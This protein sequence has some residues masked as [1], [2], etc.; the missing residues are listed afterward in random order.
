M[1]FPYI[2]SVLA[3]ALV[4]SCAVPTEDGEEHGS[5]HVHASYLPLPEQKIAPQKLAYASRGTAGTLGELDATNEAELRGVPRTSARVSGDRRITQ[6]LL[7]IAA[8]GN[9]P[10]YG[11]A[12]AAL[13]RIG[14]PYDTLFAATES[15]T[16]S[17]LTD[18]VSRCHYS[19]VILATDAVAFTD[20]ADLQW[21]SALDAGEWVLLRD[22][23]AACSARE[24][25]W[26]T[27][28]SPAYG[29]TWPSTP[30]TEIDAQLTAAG[31][32]MIKRV[33]PT[34]T[35]TYRSTYL[36]P[37]TVY[38]PTTTTAL[39]QAAD[40]SVL[41]ASHV[42][43]DGREQ[44]F[45]MADSNEYLTHSNLLE[46]DFVRWVARGMFVGKKR[47][48]LS[49]QIDDLFLANNMWDP[50]AHRNFD[51]DTTSVFRLT[52]ADLNSFVTWQQNRKATLPAG[53][54]FYT[55]LA[56]NGLGTQTTAYADTSLLTAARAAG[57]KLSWLNHTWDHDN[58]DAVT[59]SKARTEVNKNCNLA[60]L[61]K[62]NGF[63][64]SELVTP[65]MSGLR[66]QAPV[67]GM[68]DAGVRWVVSDTSITEALRPGF[69]GTNPSFNVGRKNPLDARLYQVPRHPTSI[70]YDTS[71][72]V[73]EADEYNT[74][75][76]SYYGRDL[77]YAELLDKDSEFGLH[78]L[79]TG[80]ID[81]LMFHQANLR[82]YGGGRS[83]YADWIDAVLAKYLAYSN[84]P[85]LTLR[86]SA[87]GT[88]MQ[89]RGKLNA[90][91]LTA[92]VIE[93]AGTKSLELRSTAACTVPLTGL[94]APSYGQ[95]ETYA[96]EPTTSV[97]MTANQTRIIALP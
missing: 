93:T 11:A 69:P 52:G 24:L 80:D 41:L 12:K 22:F 43:P 63:N 47:S 2:A 75:Y 77:S 13:D 88:A 56:F 85:V 48:Y 94:A 35:V 8:N 64:C 67:L 21:K 55:D 15:L 54:T 91:G 68:L 1:R 26:Y 90:C 72:P 79:L 87:I 19:G 70:F 31:Q 50:I 71:D 20:P 73:T 81:P 42:E 7:L 14:V 23:E 60:T 30:R 58:L 34:A 74:I 84:A 86:Q 92:T 4:A 83:I 62:L 53:S 28:P 49:A 40:G 61:Y 57:N 10:S 96:G 6:K 32:T 5:G 97:V 25:S 38:D 3:T 16:A 45:S 44:L 76:R 33:K 29:L 37:T 9:E 89:Q 59:R 18:D 82:N 46:Y 66:T 65:D 27:Y 51:D 39:I 36:Y 17:R 95:V 78:Y